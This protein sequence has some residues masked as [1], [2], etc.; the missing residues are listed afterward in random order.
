MSIWK[1]SAHEKHVC[2][3]TRSLTNRYTNIWGSILV[4]QHDTN[5][6]H[7]NCVP[8]KYGKMMCCLSDFFRWFKFTLKP[9]YTIMC[10]NLL[11]AIW[12]TSHWTFFFKFGLKTAWDISY[13]ILWPILKYVNFWQLQGHS[14]NLSKKDAF[15]KLIFSWWRSNGASMR[16][17]GVIGGQIPRLYGGAIF[18]GVW[19]TWGIQWG[20]EF[21]SSIFLTHLRQLRGYSAFTDLVKNQYTGVE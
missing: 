3:A 9:P 13:D 12:D 15:R 19:H 16:L 6:C 4:A 14:S 5:C 11:S 20:I 18:G 10:G 17:G 2:M 8:E 1:C 21:K 7:W